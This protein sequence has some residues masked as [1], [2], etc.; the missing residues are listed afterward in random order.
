MHAEWTRHR[1][2]STDDI[3][4]L[5]EDC[6]RNFG[7]TGSP[8][9]AM[10]GERALGRAYLW[11]PERRRDAHDY[12]VHLYDQAKREHSGWDRLVSLWYLEIWHRLEG[13]VDAVRA[14]GLETLSLMTDPPG[15][16]SEFGGEA[17]G[18]LSWVAWREGNLGQARELAI[19][20]LKEI[21]GEAF[22]PVEW[23]ARWTLLGLALRDQDWAEAAGQAAVILDPVQQ[24]M[25]DDLEELMRRLVDEQARDRAPGPGTVEAL[26]ATARTCGYL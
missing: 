1:F 20:A 8:V 13:E 24:K 7:S 23:Q 14:Y 16:W 18:H 11:S 2:V 25:P 12:L 26:T 9:D 6:A 17:R 4:A 3:L 10:R 22:S 15:V 5:A 21:R 19:R